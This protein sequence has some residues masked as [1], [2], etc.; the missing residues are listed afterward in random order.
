M[1]TTKLSQKVL[2][3]LEKKSK[4]ISVPELLVSLNEQGLSPNKTTVY[5]MLEK[6][7]QEGKV[8]SPLLDPKVMY[9]ELT[10]H[11]HHHFRCESCDGISCIDDPK[12]ESQIHKLEEKLEANGLKVS[13]H[14]FSLTGTCDACN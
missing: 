7:T 14:H 11:H 5:R 6:L 8:Q 3:I 13:D 10:S 4:P 2:D 1:R 12:L 9:Y